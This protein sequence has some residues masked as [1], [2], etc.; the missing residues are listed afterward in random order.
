[1]TEL[2]TLQQFFELSND[3]LCVASADGYLKRVNAAF[4]KT[5]GHSRETLLSRPFLEFIYTED[6]ESSQQQI[7]KLLAGQCLCN[8][9][10]RWHHSDGHLCWLEWNISS[11]TDEDGNVLF[12]AAAREISQRKV[13]EDLAQSLNIELQGKVDQATQ[14]IELYAN[15]FR[16][17]PMALNVWQLQDPKDPSSLVLRYSNPAAL[18]S[19]DLQG[20]SIIGKSI[21]DCFPG[22]D[23]AELNRYAQ[24]ARR[25]LDNQHYQLPYADENGLEGVFA[26]RLFPLPKFCLGIAFDDVTQR[27]KLKQ[28]LRDNEEHFRTIFEQAAIGIAQIDVSGQWI[29]VND[30]FCEMLRY[31]REVLLTKTFAEITDPRDAQQ[32]AAYYEQLIAGAIDTCSFEKRYLCSD[33][34][35]LWVSVAVT[36][37]RSITGEVHT[38]IAT[39]QDI[40]DRKASEKERIERAQELRRLN[41]EL[42]RATRALQ[43]RNREL[44]QFAY[45]VSHDLK[46][47]L[48]ALSSLAGWIHE[49]NSGKLGEESERHLELMQQ[50]VMRMGGLLDGLLEYSR[51]GRVNIER[52]QVEV[53][54]LLATIVDSLQ[55]PEGFN[56]EIVGPMPVLE[57]RAISLNQVFTNLISNAIR[58]C[59]RPD[60]HL[61]ISVREAEEHY[62]FSLADNGPG[63]DPQYHDRIFEIFQ[64]LQPRDKSESTGV[65]LSIVKKI[66]TVEQGEIWLDS[67]L[68]E[69]TTFHFSWPKA[70]SLK[71]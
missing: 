8:F 58:Y 53:G 26:L 64:T 2:E 27:V 12:H 6:R 30:R 47:P 22:V 10:N 69:G 21:L 70:D 25:E 11:V 46:A 65:G 16:N 49:D 32:D 17:V 51:I 60:G 38:F 41:R 57:A 3:L 1:M 19:T 37:L 54:P 40:S 67:T 55:P 56:V 7:E 42:G 45:V 13:L 9:Q 33:G 14:E 34:D 39:I 71:S 61:K 52:T 43:R 66:L 24:V 28:Q 62:E 4:S 5:L 50:R 35:S 23:E 63:I 31:D 44:D 59:D 68:M 36:A 29:E 20:E 48:R 18:N 15:L